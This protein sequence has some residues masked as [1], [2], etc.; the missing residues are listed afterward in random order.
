MFI[1]DN[2]LA[3]LIIKDIIKV[4]SGRVIELFFN[5]LFNIESKVNFYII[6]FSFF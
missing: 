1:F 3:E 4:Y 2:S 6:G 5:T